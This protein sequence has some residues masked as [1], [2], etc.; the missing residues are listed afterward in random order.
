LGFSLLLQTRFAPLNERLAMAFTD[1][2]GAG[3]HIDTIN[4][5]G[6]QAELAADTIFSNHAMEEF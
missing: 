3:N 5:T 6:W 2:L 1:R 4:G